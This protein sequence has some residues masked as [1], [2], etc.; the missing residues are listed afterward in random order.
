MN[1]QSD[2]IGIIVL[3]AGF[4][5]RFNGDKRK[6]LMPDQ[7][8][9]LD[10]TLRNI[11]LAI[12]KRILVLRPGD[13]ALAKKYQHQWNIVIAENS[14][15]GMG[16]SLCAGIRAVS[17]WQGCLLA[18]GDMPFIEPATYLMVQSSLKM[19]AIVQPKYKEQR[20]HPV[21]FQ[22]SLFPELKKLSGD[23]GARS[24]V[25]AHAEHIYELTCNDQGIVRDIDRPS[26]L[27]AGIKQL[28]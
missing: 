12:S 10:T 11:P 8:T 16:E 2:N 19:H 18:L 22:E 23:K 14:E 13:E 26:D 27:T 25:K 15:Q 28:R 5:R 9:V 7:S 24:I 17:N 20:G 4:S 21:G 3:A 1:M 6:A